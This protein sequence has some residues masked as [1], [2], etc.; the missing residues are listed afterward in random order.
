MRLDIRNFDGAHRNFLGATNRTGR[1]GTSGRDGRGNLL[2]LR[3]AGCGR[4]G[5]GNLLVL[6]GAGWRG[7]VGQC[8]LAP[9]LLFLSGRRRIGHLLGRHHLGSPGFFRRKGCLRH[10]GARGAAG[11]SSGAVWV[12]VAASRQ[13]RGLYAPARSYLPACCCFCTCLCPAS[14]HGRNCTLLR[15]SSEDRSTPCVA[16]E[17]WFELT[18]LQPSST[19]LLP[20]RRGTRWQARNGRNGLRTGCTSH[21]S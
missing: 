13:P 2:V 15:S 17:M 21:C 8:G 9:L 19:Y 10:R 14:R 7:N 16:A 4:D 20:R 3:G 11:A 12:R 5:R 1:R 18:L 6:R